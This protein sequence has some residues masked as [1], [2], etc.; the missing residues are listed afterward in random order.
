MTWHYPI[1]TFF[2]ILQF[3]VYTLKN[4]HKCAPMYLNTMFIKALFL[5]VKACKQFKHQMQNIQNNCRIDKLVLYL[6]WNTMLQW[7]PKWKRWEKVVYRCMWNKGLFFYY[8]LFLLYIF[9]VN[10]CTPTFAH[11]FIYKMIPFI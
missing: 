2:M 10:N 11:P 1:K 9:H 4:L 6:W 5:T 7:N 3:K 8:Y